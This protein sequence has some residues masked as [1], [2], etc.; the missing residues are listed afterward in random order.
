MRTLL[1]KLAA[2]YLNDK[3][4]NF[5]TDDQGGWIAGE[6]WHVNFTRAPRYRT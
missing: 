6:K 2:W 4:I 1:A 3:A 5:V